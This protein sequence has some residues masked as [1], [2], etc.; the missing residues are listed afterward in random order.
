MPRS[1][2]DPAGRAT[3]HADIRVTKSVDRLLAVADDENRRLQRQVLR[4]AFAF[5]PR[6]HEVPDQPPLGIARVLELVDEQMVIARLEQ[7]AAARELVHRGDEIE[8]ARQGVRE[9]DDGVLL[10]R[11]AVLAPSDGK[12]PPDTAGEDSVQV[13][14]KTVRRLGNRRRALLQQLL[15]PPPRHVAGEELLL[16]ERPLARFVLSGEEVMPQRV[17]Q[18]PAPLRNASFPPVSSPSRR[19]RSAA[20]SLKRG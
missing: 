18:Q 1:S 7:K 8:R 17:Q 19:A 9:V 3:Q 12:E 13:A 5:A 4:E 6:L 14:G 15:V 20:S 2:E 16:V 10:E 11:L